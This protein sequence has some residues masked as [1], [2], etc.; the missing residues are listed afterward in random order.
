MK[1]YDVVGTRIDKKKIFIIKIY[2]VIYRLRSYI[3]CLN[4]M[5]LTHIAI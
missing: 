3:G 5:R 4:E 2:S 1:G